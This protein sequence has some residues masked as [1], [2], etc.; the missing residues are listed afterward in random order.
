M[1]LAGLLLAGV[2]FLHAAEETPPAG[3]WKIT[4]PF[5]QSADRPQWLVKLENKD[6]K[7]TGSVL[8][9][10]EGKTAVALEK[11]SVTKESL[12]F[13]LKSPGQSVPCVFRLPAKTETKLY[14]VL[15][16]GGRVIPAEMERTALTSL[17]E[18]ELLKETLAKAK[19][20]ADAMR[21]A[22]NLLSVAG[23]SHAKPEE[24]RSWAARA[25]KAAEL[26]GPHWQRDVILLVIKILDGQKGYESIALTYARQAER[27]LEDRDRPGVRKQVLDALAAA[28]TKAGKTDEAKEVEA[29]AKKIDLAIKPEP[30]AGRKGKSDRVVLVELFTGAECPPCVAADLAFDALGKAFKPSEVV[31][32]QYHLHIP[33]PDPLTNPAS[34]ARANYY[35]RVIEGTPTM[36]LNGKPAA[37]GGGGASEGW[38]K[39]DEYAESLLPLLETPAKAKLKATANRKGSKIQIDVTASDMKADGADLR[40]RVALV[41]ERITYTGGNKLAEHHHVVRAFAGGVNGEKVTADKPFT[42]SLT[43]DLGDVKKGLLDY[44]DKTS[45]NMPFPS[46][47][48]PLDLKNLRVVAFVQND[49]THEVLQAIQIDVAAE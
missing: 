41:E 21:A 4:L 7:W 9:K 12:R 36:L 3:T 25:V 35:G 40:L 16:P 38:E 18:T 30:F 46:K 17:S 29:R 49:T 48:R 1:A 20:N 33:G 39:Y 8:D 10:A 6:G 11:L 24:V 2:G 47:D 42:K 31:R 23:E 43:V 15:T 37:S 34:E 32:L 22:L 26:Y 28:L 44:L 27:L 13:T 5:L 14:G 45:K 19:E